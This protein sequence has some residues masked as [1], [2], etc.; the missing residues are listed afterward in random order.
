MWDG[1]Q[2][3]YKILERK[4]SGRR[5]LDRAGKKAAPDYAGF[6]KPGQIVE[7]LFQGLAETIKGF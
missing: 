5:T 3:E 4:A 1:S 6:L 7:T 2:G